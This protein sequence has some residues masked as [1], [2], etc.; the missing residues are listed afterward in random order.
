MSIGDDNESDDKTEKVFR[1][2]DKEQMYTCS[3]STRNYNVMFNKKKD[4][5]QF[6]K[7]ICVINLF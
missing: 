4:D 3:L 2:K 1:I 5:Y 6:M 7:K